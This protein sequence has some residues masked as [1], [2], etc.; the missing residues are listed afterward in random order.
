MGMPATAQDGAVA[1]NSELVDDPD[2]AFRAGEMIG[3]LTDG[4]L[5]VS[6]GSSAAEATH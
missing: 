6:P 1:I 3:A 4:P 2:A 5:G